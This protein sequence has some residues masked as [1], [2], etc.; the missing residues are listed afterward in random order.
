MGTKLSVVVP[1]YNG[2]RYVKHCIDSIRK[3]LSKITKSDDILYFPKAI[4]NQLIIRYYPAFAKAQKM[5]A[6]TL[7]AHISNICW[8][9]M[10]GRCYAKDVALL[11]AFEWRDCTEETLRPLE[12]HFISR[13]PIRKNFALL[14]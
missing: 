2:E 8:L 9:H 10:D 4:L 7:P 11:L 1:V 6:S 13:M 14:F 3:K 5:C 12:R